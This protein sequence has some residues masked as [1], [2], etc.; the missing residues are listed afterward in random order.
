MNRS[1]ASTSVS[2]LVGRQRRPELARLDRLAQP[3]PLPVRR[4]VLD[5]VGDRPAVG[6]A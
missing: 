5:L 3:Q 1:S 4:D 6:L 2:R